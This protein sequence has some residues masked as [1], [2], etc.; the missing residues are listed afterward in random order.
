MTNAS[1]TRALVLAAHDAVDEIA[2]GFAAIP[3]TGA[4][5]V[6]TAGGG[7]RAAFDAAEGFDPAWDWHEVAELGLG[8]AAQRKGRRSLGPSAVLQ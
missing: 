8:R 1:P 3:T 6:L 2:R 4:G 5:E 7:S